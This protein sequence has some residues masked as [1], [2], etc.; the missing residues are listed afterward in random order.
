MIPVSVDANL[1]ARPVAAHFN[2]VGTGSTGTELMV[3]VEYQVVTAGQH[4]V[5]PHGVLRY[6]REPILV[7]KVG[8]HVIVIPVPPTARNAGNLVTDEGRSARVSMRSDR[9]KVDV[10]VGVVVIVVF[11]GSVVEI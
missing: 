8:S 7:P 4:L 9:L 10:I 6:A 1:H 2:L 5:D 3:Q 11:S